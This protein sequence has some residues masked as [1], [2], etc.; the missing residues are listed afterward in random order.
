MLHE[1]FFKYCEVIHFLVSKIVYDWI[2]DSFVQIMVYNMRDF[3]KR[4]HFCYVI[5]VQGVNVKNHKL[6]T[7]QGKF[8]AFTNT[9]QKGPVCCAHSCFELCSAWMDNTLSYCF[10]E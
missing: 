4:S 8:L 7:L 10:S 5:C 3:G 1:Y 2:G 9:E 6:R